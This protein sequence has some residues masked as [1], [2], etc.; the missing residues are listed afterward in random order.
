M[1]NNKH[2][3]N[4]KI[5][6]IATTWLV[7]VLFLSC[8]DN[9]IDKIRSFTHPP[10]SPSLTA[11]NIE[12]LYSDSAV[13]RFMLNAPQVK[14]YNDIDDPYKEFPEGFIITQ[15]NRNNEVTSY[16]EATYGKYYEKKSLWEA[17]QNVMAVTENNDTLLTDVLFWD[18][19]NDLIY[20]DQFVKFIQQENIITGIGFESDLQMQRWKIKNTVKGTVV[21]EVEE[22]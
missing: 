5:I 6:S 1:L 21:V 10:G 20:S 15:F 11:K 2:N 18:E 13:I 8:Q 16:I 19:E 12:L 4:T 17:R 3:I 22:E 14:I 7:A 9:N